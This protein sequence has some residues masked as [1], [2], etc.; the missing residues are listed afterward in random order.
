[1]GAE[2]LLGSLAEH[3]LSIFLLLEGECACKGSLLMASL[4]GYSGGT[5]LQLSLSRLA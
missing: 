1:M 2:E 5:G 4:C 3:N